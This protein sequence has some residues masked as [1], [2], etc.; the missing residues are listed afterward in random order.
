MRA[1]NRSDREE[2]VAA[3]TVFDHDRLTPFR[4]KLVRQ[5]PGRSSAATTGCTPSRSRSR[6]RDAVTSLVVS[7]FSGAPD[8]S[9]PIDPETCGTP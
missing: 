2:S 4:R 6:R 8:V 3:G 5:H 9:R 1:Q 7:A